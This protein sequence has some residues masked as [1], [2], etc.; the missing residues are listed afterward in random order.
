[1]HLFGG[2]RR[3]F[4]HS[5]LCTVLECALCPSCF[6][7]CSPKIHKNI[8]P[9]L[10]ASLLVPS[11]IQVWHHHFPSNPVLGCFLGSSPSIINFFKLCYT[12]APPRLYGPAPP[13]LPTCS[14][15]DRVLSGRQ[16]SPSVTT[17]VHVADWFGMKIQCCLY[18]E[19]WRD[20]A[21]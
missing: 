2:Q 10:Q 17:E 20:E 5:S 4:L 18:W 13:A 15:H 9:V 6:H 11:G 12:S 8:M 7:H 19:S 16:F 14:C 1:M 3:N 21:W